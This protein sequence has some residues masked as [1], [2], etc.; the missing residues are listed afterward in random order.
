[1]IYKNVEILFAN[2][3]VPTA[4]QS[5]L[6][7]FPTDM[8]KSLPMGQNPG[9]SLSKD[10]LEPTGPGDLATQLQ[11]Q[12]I[13]D[14]IAASCAEKTFAA[15]TISDI[16][17][18]AGVSRATFYKS[19]DNKRCCFDAAADH[20]VQ[21]LWT[22]GGAVRSDTATGPENVR[23]ALAA[24]LQLMATAPTYTRLLIIETVTVNPR[25]V[26]RFRT[27]II[28][29]LRTARDGSN[30]SQPSDPPDAAIR[31]AF[32]QAQVLVANQILVGHGDALPVLLPDLVYIA[33]L[34]FAGEEEALTQAQ[35][36]R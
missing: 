34:P 11:R 29:A 6:A 1:M 22:A 18:R 26:D 31:T 27:L 13:L 16:V 14:A 9:Q 8:A 28:R 12:R 30:D 5:G 25:L 35:L 10:V 3:S 2:I 7:A 33:L 15:T 23:N 4:D 17:G 20:F 24:A 21:K 32:G 36:A 19:F